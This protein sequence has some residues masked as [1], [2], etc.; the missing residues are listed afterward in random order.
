MD[1]YMLIHTFIHIQHS[2][3]RVYQ[4]SDLKKEKR[5]AV[6]EILPYLY[7]RKLGMAIHLPVVSLH[8]VWTKKL[9]DSGHLDDYIMQWFRIAA[10]V[11]ETTQST[12]NARK[13]KSWQCK[14][15]L[16]LF[17]QYQGPRTFAWEYSQQGVQTHIR[18]AGDRNW[19][20][21]DKVFPTAH[22]VL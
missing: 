13:T 14:V 22:N 10:S 9:F 15:K 1:L 2:K 7:V 3:E 19:V 6:Q 17:F 8:N 11:Y 4:E 5:F 12:T 18:Y 21:E 16:Q 20:L